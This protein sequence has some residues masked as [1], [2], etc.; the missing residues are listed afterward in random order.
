MNWKLLLSLLIAIVV[1]GGLGWLLTRDS[2][3]LEAPGQI[4][5]QSEGTDIPPT[6]RSVDGYA[7]VDESG[8]YLRSSFGTSTVRIPDADP[9]SFRAVGK[10]GEYGNQEILDFC[11]GPG[12]YGLYADRSKTYLFQFWKTPTFGKTRIEVVKE[13]NPD[14]LSVID[15]L[16]FTSGTTTL[17]LGYKFATTSCS[18]I[19]EPA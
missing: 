18:F 16:T 19:L 9:D 4:I 1:F 5:R 7:F 2:G 11:K 15:P 14:T 13:L 3:K 6:A 10:L 8:V 12:N 17:R